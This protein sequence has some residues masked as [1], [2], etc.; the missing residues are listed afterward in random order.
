MSVDWIKIDLWP[1]GRAGIDARFRTTATDLYLYIEGTNHPLDWLHHVT[2]FA[3][4]REREA[5][6]L[7]YRK[8][9][10][11]VGARRV[12]IGGHSLGGAVAVV[13]ANLFAEAP[14]L[15][16][17]AGKR[18]PEGPRWGLVAYR[19]KGDIVPFLPPTRKAWK[20]ENV[21][22]SWTP[23]FWKVHHPN[24]YRRFMDRDGYGR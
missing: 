24:N 6:R 12:N 2:P 7:L 15:T 16:V 19:R 4:L 10:P 23:L 1:H 8:I 9:L 11:Y 5:G 3:K 22:G 21:F 13:V 18:P 14:T 17:Y 20:G